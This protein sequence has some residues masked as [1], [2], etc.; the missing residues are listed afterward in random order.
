MVNAQSISHLDHKE[1]LTQNTEYKVKEC[2]KESESIK[3]LQA[4]K[5]DLT[6]VQNKVEHLRLTFK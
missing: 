3:R 6:D 4:E 5:N 1:F 2:T